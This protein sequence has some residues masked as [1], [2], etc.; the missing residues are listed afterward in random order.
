MLLLSK[1]EAMIG[2]NDVPQ[3]PQKV[4]GELPATT[5]K[6]NE[7]SGGSGRSAHLLQPESS[8][9]LS[10]SV[11]LFVNFPSASL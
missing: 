1:V 9:T 3:F 6:C 8:D 7:G 11:P 2:F 5:R 10:H 4:V